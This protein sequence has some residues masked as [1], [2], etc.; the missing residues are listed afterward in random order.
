[1]YR[2]CCYTVATQTELAIEGSVFC[3]TSHFESCVCGDSYL[4]Y[5]SMIVVYFKIV[6]YWN[7]RARDPMTACLGINI[8][9]E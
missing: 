9:L 5:S 8:S 3:N 2:L 7:T 4:I 6:K 1:M